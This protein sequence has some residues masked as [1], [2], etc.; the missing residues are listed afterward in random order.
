VREDAERLTERA[1]RRSS[2]TSREP[3][4][5]RRADRNSSASFAESQ[6]IVLPEPG[7]DLER[8]LR[9]KLANWR[10][11]LNRNVD[12][13]RDVLRILLVDSLRFTPLV[14]GA[15]RAYAFEGAIALERLVS[16]VIELPTLWSGVP[17]GIREGGP[18]RRT[19]AAR[20]IGEAR[21]RAITGTGLR[22]TVGVPDGTRPR[23]RP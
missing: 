6:A 12:A 7:A 17:D 11:L 10:H 22:K 20:S 9:E 4:R 3:P 23:V 19:T 13:A 1:R 5:S 8:R 2:S 18:R 14:E 21:L 16:G 15:R